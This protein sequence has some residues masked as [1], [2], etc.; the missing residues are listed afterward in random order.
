MNDTLRVGQMIVPATGRL[1][2]STAHVTAL[3]SKVDRRNLTT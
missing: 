3:A 2:Q 1:G